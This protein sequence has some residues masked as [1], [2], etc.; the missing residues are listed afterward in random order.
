MDLRP[1]ESGP[2]SKYGVFIGSGGVHVFE[3]M[4]HMIK[5]IITNIDTLL[6]R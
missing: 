1:W 3:G 5:N 2:R 4:E 6:D